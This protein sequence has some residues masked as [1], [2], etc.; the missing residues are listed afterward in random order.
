MK[1]DGKRND[2]NHIE[3]YFSL[4]QSESDKIKRLETLCVFSLQP[5]YLESFTEAI[6]SELEIIKTFEISVK[7]SLIKLNSSD[8]SFNIYK[9]D[10]KIFKLSKTSVDVKRVLLYPSNR[11]LEY[12]YVLKG[13][14][15]EKINNFS[16]GLD[17]RTN[18]NEEGMNIKNPL[19]QVNKNLKAFINYQQFVK[20]LAEQSDEANIRIYKAG[21]TSSDI[22]IED[23]LEYIDEI[24]YKEELPF[25]DFEF[26]ENLNNNIAEEFVKKV[27]NKI[28]WNLNSSIYQYKEDLKQ[29]QGEILG[30]FIEKY[31][32]IKSFK[33]SKKVGTTIKQNTEKQHGN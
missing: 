25:H 22:N 26:T 15:T 31:T 2:I 8:T 32:L 9:K 23:V 3:D 24:K 5:S 18:R 1:N 21:A 29:S 10:L 13:K 11:S 19:K 30:D 16:F 27:R 6:S 17:Y 33:L 12:E 28:N 4:G 7:P 20:T 14:H